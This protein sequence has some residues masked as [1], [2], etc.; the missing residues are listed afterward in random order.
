MT[1]QPTKAQWEEI[2]NALSHPYGMAYFKCDDYLVSARIEQSKMRLVIAVYVNGYIRGR[3]TWSGKACHL[4]EM[5]EI[6][7][8]FY[9]LSKKHKTAKEIDLNNKIFGKKR[10]KVEGI[11]DPLCHALPWFNTAG[12]FVAH[13]KKHNTSIEVL[14]CERYQQLLVELQPKVNHV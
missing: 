2:K 7:R 8:R 14:D 1:T 3:W 11:N 5:P 9:F 10:C 12:A 4:N 13:L 6:P